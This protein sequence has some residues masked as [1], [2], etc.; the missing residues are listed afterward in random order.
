MDDLTLDAGRPVSA[1]RASSDAIDRRLVIPGWVVTTM[2]TY[3]ASRVVNYAGMWLGGAMHGRPPLAAVLRAWDGSWWVGL[4]MNGYPDEVVREGGKAVQSH[5]AF[6]PLFPMI[7]RPVRWLLGVS[8]DVASAVVTLTFGAVAA[9]LLY[10]LVRH[11]LDADVAARSVALFC[12]FPGSWVLGIPYSEGVFVALAI[13]SMLAALR[14]RWIL[15][16]VLAALASASRPTGIFLAPALAWPAL[17]AIW[18]SREWR[19]LLAPA[20]AP[21]GMLAYFVYLWRRTGEPLAWFTVQADGWAYSESDLGMRALRR[22]GE[23]LFSDPFG[24]LNTVTG[25]AAAV[26]VIIGLVLMV[27]WR[28]PAMVTI[29]TALMSFQILT[30]GLPSRIRYAFACFPLLVAVARGVGPRFFPALLGTSAALL[31]IYTILST[32]TTLAIP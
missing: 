3:A 22:T 23:F 1:G 24:D 31:G 11:L 15:A 30:G 7:V 29:Y 6:F 16:G 12:F 27:G 28:P 21:I 13:G 32:T 25:T 5:I 20:L 26:F 9:L 19:A 8:Y 14:R 17:T 4:M 2:V 18:R 10:A